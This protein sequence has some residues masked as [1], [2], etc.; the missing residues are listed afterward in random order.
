MT[1]LSDS[2]LLF[3]SLVYIQEGL[4][5][6]CQSIYPIALSSSYFVVGSMAVG[7]TVE[8]VR[9]KVLEEDNIQ[10]LEDSILLLVGS[11]VLGSSCCCRSIRSLLKEQQLCTMRSLMTSVLLVSW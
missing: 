11:M 9:S 3:K 6:S 2:Q 5:P 10:A 8:L 7:S 4:R 1:E